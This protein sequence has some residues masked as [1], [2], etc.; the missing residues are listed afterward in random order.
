MQV[1]IKWRSSSFKESREE[2]NPT[3]NYLLR[4][5][6]NMNYLLSVTPPIKNLINVLCPFNNLA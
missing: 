1:L 5:L 6:E 4:L 3:E 2:S